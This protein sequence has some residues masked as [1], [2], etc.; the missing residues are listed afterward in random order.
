[1]RLDPA[2][3]RAMGLAVRYTRDKCSEPA[4]LRQYFALIESFRSTGQRSAARQG[5]GRTPDRL[6]PYEN[7]TDGYPMR[8]PVLTYHAIEEL[9]PPVGLSR[10]RF[11][12]HMSC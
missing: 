3:R 5:Q 9:P 7:R 4:Y 8:L 10:A 12:S 11:A 2:R 1:M 6:A